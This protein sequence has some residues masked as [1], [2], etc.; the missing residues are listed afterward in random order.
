MAYYSGV[1]LHEHPAVNVYM[2]LIKVH[3]Q[4]GVVGIATKL[5]DGSEIF[6]SPKHPSWFWGPHIP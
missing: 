6:S 2:K 1:I 5:Q 4:D 3:V